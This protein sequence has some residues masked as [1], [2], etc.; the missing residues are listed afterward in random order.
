[1]TSKKSR[2]AQKRVD[3]MP[4]FLAQEVQLASLAPLVESVRE[5]D[6]W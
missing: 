5:S 2:F 1:M 6:S 3:S 4:T